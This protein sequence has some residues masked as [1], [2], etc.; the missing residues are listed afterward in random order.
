MTQILN[1]NSKRKTACCGDLEHY[2]DGSSKHL[3]YIIVPFSSN[4]CNPSQ[5]NGAILEPRPKSP[6]CE[7]GLVGCPSNK[8]VSEA[9]HQMRE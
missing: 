9:K 3:L 2:S 5:A 1:H 7:Q 4:G 6:P 8:Q